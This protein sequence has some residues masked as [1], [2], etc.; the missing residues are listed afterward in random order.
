MHLS[1]SLHYSVVWR[2]RNRRAVFLCPLLTLVCSLLWCGR[3][4]GEVQQDGGRGLR[5][6][7]CPG[8][9]QPS[10]VWAAVNHRNSFLISLRSCSA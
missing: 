7:P 5:S 10:N 8:I 2:P 9:L 1:K 4:Q 6:A 3:L